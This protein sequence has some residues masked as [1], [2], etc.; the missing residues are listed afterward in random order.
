MVRITIAII[1]RYRNIS[2]LNS[3]LLQFCITFCIKFISLK[4]FL[5]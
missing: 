4:I 5:L 2:V 1:E 3:Y